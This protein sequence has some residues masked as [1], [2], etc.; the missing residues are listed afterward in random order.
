MDAG[1][2]IEARH[3]AGNTGGRQDWCRQAGEHGHWTGGMQDRR[4][5]RQVIRRKGVMST[6]LLFNLLVQHW[7]TKKITLRRNTHISLSFIIFILGVF[8]ETIVYRRKNNEM[9]S[10]VGTLYCT[11]A[12]R[13]WRGPI[14]RK[15]AACVGVGGFSTPCSHNPL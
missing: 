11:V 4:C 3:K 14:R 15:T 12:I 13:P 9:H 2:R 8:S 6:C 10:I 1:Y 5:A 7:Q